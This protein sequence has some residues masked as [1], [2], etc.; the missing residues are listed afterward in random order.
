MS[1]RI[2]KPFG[3]IKSTITRRDN[4]DVCTFKLKVTFNNNFS[5]IMR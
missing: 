2:L 5:L 4:H 1:K 3:G